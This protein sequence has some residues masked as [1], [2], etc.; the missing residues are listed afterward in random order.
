MKLPEVG[1]TVEIDNSCSSDDGLKGEI[2]S[3]EQDKIKVKWAD[4]EIKTL[5]IRDLF[6]DRI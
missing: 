1:E 2:V 3:V 6:R 4:G 5:Q